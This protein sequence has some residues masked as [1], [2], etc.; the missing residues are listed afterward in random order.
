MRETY[1]NRQVSQETKKQ[2][3]ESAEKVQA[4][5]QYSE[6]VITFIK[7]AESAHRSTD[8]SELVFNRSLRDNPFLW[9]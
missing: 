9:L 4:D 2:F 1:T 8:K 7:K 5:I 3:K 6:E